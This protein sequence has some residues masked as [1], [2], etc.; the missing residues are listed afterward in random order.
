MMGDFIVASEG[1]SFGLPEG[2]HSLIPRRRHAEPTAADLA[3]LAKELIWTGRRISGA[4][5]KEYRIVNH[6]VEKGKALA[7]VREIVEEKGSD[8][9]QP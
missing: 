6:V 3:P 7:K 1:A 8:R 5:A 4:E 9:W 2:K